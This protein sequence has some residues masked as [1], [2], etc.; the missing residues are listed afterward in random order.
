ML[1]FNETKEEREFLFTDYYKRYSP[2]QN[3][4]R[5]ISLSEEHCIMESFNEV[6]SLVQDYCKKQMTEVAYRVWIEPIEPRKLENNVVTLYVASKFKKD[7]IGEK[8]SDLIMEA[9]EN[10]L[11]FHADLSFITGEDAPAADENSKENADSYKNPNYEYTFE[12]FVVGSSNK[13]AHA[14]AQAVA[15]NPGGTYNPLFIYGNSGLGKTHLLNAI[16]YEIHKNNPQTP[17]YTHA[18]KILPMSSSIISVKKIQMSFTTNTATP[19]S[20]SSTIFSSSQAK[21]KLRRNFST[22]STL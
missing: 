20:C 3:I 21:P 11:G 17:S 9:L 15:A 12:T 4:L 22:L 1:K 7:I 6:W 2:L 5:A 13:F 19:T 10:I 14:A 8:Y 16:C 18:E